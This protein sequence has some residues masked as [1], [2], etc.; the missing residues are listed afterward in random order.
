MNIPE[1]W[2]Y[3]ELHPPGIDYNSSAEA[4]IYDRR[5]GQFRDLTAEANLALDALGVAPGGSLVDL[6]AG[7][8]TFAIQ[9]ARRGLRVHAVDVS[10]AMLE[11]AKQ[12]ASEAGVAVS[13]HHAGFLTYEHEGAPADFIT[14]TFAFH[15]LPDFWKGIALKRLHAVLRTGGRLYLRD[16][17]LEEADALDN[18]ARFNE[19]QAAFGGEPL[20]MDAE[21]HFRNEYSTYDWVMEGLF[22]RA[23]FQIL[24]RRFEGGVLG[25]Y[26]CERQ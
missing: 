2:R 15:H 5:H 17:I 13:F 7:T 14:T 8:G 18:I 19:R 9:A 22:E 26:V 12:K 6:G 21:G 11:V 16:V 10:E 25:T 4:A 1:A 24:S 23:G 20:R 3:D